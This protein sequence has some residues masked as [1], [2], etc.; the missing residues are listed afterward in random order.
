MIE[1]YYLGGDLLAKGLRITGKLKGTGVHMENWV[2]K[3]PG[4]DDP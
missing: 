1:R 3:N 4:P 2:Y